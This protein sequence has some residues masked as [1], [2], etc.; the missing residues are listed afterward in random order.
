MGYQFNLYVIR[1]DLQPCARLQVLRQG[2]RCNIA[3]VPTR[4][5]LVSN[6]TYSELNPISHCCV[7]LDSSSKIS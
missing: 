2:T 4:W 7:A 1:M 5:Q 3:V 6:L